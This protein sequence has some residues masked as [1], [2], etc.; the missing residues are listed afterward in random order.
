[1]LVEIT[2]FVLLFMLCIVVA[3]MATSMLMDSI[4]ELDK[5]IQERK[6]RKREEGNKD[7]QNNKGD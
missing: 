6:K 1:M 4:R 3:I 7:G 5:W 2:V